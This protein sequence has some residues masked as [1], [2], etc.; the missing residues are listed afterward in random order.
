MSFWQ[1][2]KTLVAILRGHRRYKKAVD[3]IRAVVALQQDVTQAVLEPYRRGDYEAALQAVGV[4]KDASDA[5][6]ANTYFFYRGIMLTNLG[7][8][9][10]AEQAFR[11]NLTVAPD[12]K[13]RALAYSSFGR[14]LLEMERYTE[15]SECFDAS[16][17]FWP[18]RGSPHRGLAEA[19]LRQGGDASTAARRA[20]IAVQEE[21]A[22]MNPNDS[23][24]AQSAYNVNL[25]EN[26]ATL[27]W[28]V[29]A[30]SQDRA[31]VDRMVGEAVPLA[32][33]PA[34]SAAQVHFHSAQAYLVLGDPV[35]SANHLSEAARIDPHG[36]FGRAAQ[37]M[38]LGANV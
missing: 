35:E 7:R 31:E 20:R 29:A 32:A 5:R 37:A 25:A 12:E 24:Q 8:F 10:E 23:P 9:E 1:L 30:E 13:R 14:L 2:I 17:R 27:A 26:L 15:A 22:R 16:L 28:A 38:L 6:L 33:G 4:L 19:C 21:R 18:D 11:R 34:S 3:E 36:V